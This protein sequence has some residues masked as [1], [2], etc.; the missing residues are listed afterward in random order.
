MALDPGAKPV[1]RL[2][3]REYLLNLSS[4]LQREAGQAGAKGE[5]SIV[6]S[7]ELAIEMSDRL[8]EIAGKL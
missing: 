7:R 4:A 1:R 5:S 3:D 2:K 6:V 8:S